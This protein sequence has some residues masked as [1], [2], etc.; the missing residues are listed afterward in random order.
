M[1]WKSLPQVCLKIV[2]MRHYLKTILCLSESLFAVKTILRT[3][4]LVSRLHICH[5]NRLT[6]ILLIRVDQ[7]PSLEQGR[8][9]WRHNNIIHFNLSCLD[10][11]KFSVFIDLPGHT[12]PNGGSV[13]IEICVTPLKPDITILDKKNK[14]FN[15]FWTNLPFWNQHQQNKS[16]KIKQIYLN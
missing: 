16:A 3:I 7:L 6:D 14:T 11:E 8:Y 1:K 9:T 4:F 12:T 10:T 2:V 15:T 5:L 13:T